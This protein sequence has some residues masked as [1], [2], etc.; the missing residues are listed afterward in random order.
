VRASPDR[1]RP[2]QRR[3]KPAERVGGGL[4]FLPPGSPRP[5]SYRTRSTTLTRPSPAGPP[6]PSRQ[7]G[8]PPA[9]AMPQRGEARGRIKSIAVEAARQRKADSASGP[10]AA[11]TPRTGEGSKKIKNAGYGGGDCAHL[12]AG[13]DGQELHL[14]AG[15]N[16]AGRAMHDP[17]L[18]RRRERRRSRRVA[19]GDRCT[20]PP[21]PADPRSAATCL[22][23]GQRERCGRFAPASGACSLRVRARPCRPD[24][25]EAVP[26]PATRYDDEHQVAIAAG[27][28]G[29]APSRTEP[30][31][32]TSRARDLRPTTVA[33]PYNKPPQQPKLQL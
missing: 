22:P 4:D 29:E 23:G 30:I 17:S 11:A 12:T 15:S 24:G 20:I 9:T 7:R 25:A 6:E 26:R 14:E 33:E 16:C 2:L 1:G 10:A 21:R 19:P 31:K 13:I 28:H 5:P 3:S 27:P 32:K 18:E 8:S